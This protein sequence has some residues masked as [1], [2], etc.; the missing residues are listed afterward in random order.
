M[1]GIRIFDAPSLVCWCIIS[2]RAVDEGRYPRSLAAALP[3]DTGRIDPG[4]ETVLVVAHEASRTGAPILGY[5][6]AKR[7]AA[8]YNVVT[9]LLSGGEIASA[10]DD[11]SQAVVGPLRR[12]DWHPVEAEYLVRR[13]LS[14][15]GFSYAIANSIDSR[16]VVKPLAYAFV[17]VVALVHEFAS[18]LSPAGEMGRELGWATQSVFSSK[19]VLE[20]VRAEYPNVDNYRIHILPQGPPELPPAGPEAKAHAE[21]TLKAAMRPAGSEDAFVVLGCGTIYPR[22]G[23]DLFMACAAAI[24]ARTILRGR[25]RF[26]WIGQV[27]PPELDKGYFAKLQKQIA[28]ARIADKI[29]IVEEVADLEAAYSMADA[30]FL[31]SRLDP[32]PNV[33]IDSALRG[34]PVVCFENCSGISDILATDSIARAS[35]VPHLDVEAAA[36]LVST[37]AADEPLRQEIGAASRRLAQ[38]NFNMELY[39]DRLDDVGRESMRIMEQRREDFVT[40]Q[41]DELFDTISFLGPDSEIVTREDA[42]RLFIAKS[43]MLGTGRQP[44]TN[45]YY[46][47]PC[48]GFHPQIYAHENR[49]R[50]DASMENP[51]AHFIRAGKPAGRWRH[52][53][54]TPDNTDSAEI[55]TSSV[56]TRIACSFSLSGALR[57]ISRN[58]GVE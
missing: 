4:R 54:I 42:I 33:A 7:L 26:V 22:K 14:T 15:Y 25:V 11:V 6:I 32:L 23:V 50:Y 5:N 12:Q 53:V 2:R 29:A 46:R 52:Q 56:R 31:S 40:I 55:S 39:I 48:P 27:L 43:A 18:Y 34:L 16:L 3:L 9:L 20:L 28:Q 30:F 36:Q 41:A 58:D 13:L 57:R 17:P 35:V 51:L 38:A 44:T 21:H 45:F 8:K 24:A 37:L 47:R 49:S 10:F 19:R 1:S